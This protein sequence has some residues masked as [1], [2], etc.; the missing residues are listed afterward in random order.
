MGRVGDTTVVSA[1]VAIASCRRT[2][3]ADPRDLYPDPDAQPLQ[4]ALSIMG[5]SSVLV[6]WDD[7][8]MAWEDFPRVV[9]S[10][11]WDSVDRP[12]EYLAWARSTAAATM[13]IN[14][15]AFIEW[16]LDKRHQR[17]LAS[18]GV[19]VVPTVWVDPGEPWEPPASTQFVVKPSVSAGGRSTARYAASDEAAR[20]HVRA[21]QSAGQTVMVQDYLPSIDTDGELNVIFINGAFSHAVRKKAALQVGHGV[22]ERPWERMKWEGVAVPDARQ[23]EVA[24]STLAVIR[25][26]M[27]CYP[28][29]G[30]V[31]LINGPA[32]PVLLEVELIDPYLSLD[33][34][35]SAAAR[36][37]KMIIWPR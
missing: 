15:L 3:D 28:T 4:A 10:S 9:V 37:A 17:E 23:M 32:G 6:S 31:D 22:V 7:P 16:N 27:G 18:A 19:P 36:L 30:R 12:S 20:A 24:D 25:R 5:A 29:Y 13:L 14:D 21:L 11:T 35:P 26:R 33:M 34:D 1:D 2:A 8:S